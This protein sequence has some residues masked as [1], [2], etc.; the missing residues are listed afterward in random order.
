ML[1]WG[2]GFRKMNLNI[3]LDNVKYVKLTLQ[4][5]NGNS[6]TVRSA[7]K[8]MDKRE[9]IVCSKFDV[10]L[11]IKSPQD[12]TM[13]IVCLDGLY[14]TKAKL[15]SFEKDEPYVFFYLECEVFRFAYTCFTFIPTKP[16]IT[17]VRGCG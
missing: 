2:R 15:K 10:E 9:I 1:E 8:K 12:V 13:S 5:I 16:S 17:Y 14:R 4:E 3:N 7:I 6:A 11:S